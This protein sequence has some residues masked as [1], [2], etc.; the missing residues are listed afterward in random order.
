MVVVG[1]Y[2]ESQ[3]AVFRPLV[4][5]EQ[6]IEPRT[7]E[8]LLPFLVMTLTYQQLQMDLALESWARIP[9]APNACS[10]L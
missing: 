2:G 4:R 8:S 6:A 3:R 5:E 9:T 10:D 1:R 7:L